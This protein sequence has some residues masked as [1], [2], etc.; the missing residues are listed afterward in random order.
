MTPF[1]VDSRYTSAD[2]FPMFDM[3]F[4]YGNGWSATDD[5]RHVRAWR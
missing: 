4:L 5:D 1:T 3:P 2:I